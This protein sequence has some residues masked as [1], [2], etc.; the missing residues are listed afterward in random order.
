M[1]CEDD[2][3]YRRLEN[4]IYDTI[5]GESVQEFEG[6]QNQARYFKPAELAHAQVK[7]RLESFKTVKN[8]LEKEFKS[9]LL[10]I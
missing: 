2:V 9:Q 1:E 5:L 7:K 6:W 10:R 8:E 3:C 4:R